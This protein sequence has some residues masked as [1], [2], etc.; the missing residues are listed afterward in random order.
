MVPPT[1]TPPTVCPV[2]VPYPPRLAEDSIPVDPGAG[3][4]LSRAL[5]E[6]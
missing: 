5:N 1:P 6:E 3:V 4:V 2:P